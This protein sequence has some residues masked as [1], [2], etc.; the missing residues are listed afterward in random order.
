MDGLYEGERNEATTELWATIAVC[1]IG[2]LY[3]V[4]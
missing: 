3:R 1:G 2:A 4:A